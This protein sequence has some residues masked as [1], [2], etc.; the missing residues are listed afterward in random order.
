MTWWH[1]GL[2]GPGRA[3]GPER[4]RGPSAGVSAG[5]VP[6]LPGIGFGVPVRPGVYSVLPSFESWTSSAMPIVISESVTAPL[7]ITR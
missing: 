2:V 7:T 6:A 3:V 5:S 1:G 4:R